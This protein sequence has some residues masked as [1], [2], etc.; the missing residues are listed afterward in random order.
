MDEDGPIEPVQPPAADDR[1]WR[2]PAEQGA[3][4]AAANLD[5]RRSYRRIWPSVCVAFVAGCCVVGLA[6]MLVDSKQRAPIEQVLVQEIAPS[7]IV[8]DGTLSFDDWVN[9]VAQLNRSSVVLLHLPDSAPTATAQAIL[10]RDD[11]HLMTS[12]HAIAGAEEITVEYAGGRLPA[13]IVGVDAVSGVAVL[14]INSPNLAPP[15][16]GDESRVLTR[17]QLVAL[18]YSIADGESAKA[19]DLHGKD[20]VATSLGGTPLAQLFALSNDLDAQ[21]AGS[22]LLSEDGG[23]IAMTVPVANGSSYAVPI[24]LARRVANQLIADGTVDHKPWIGVE[25]SPALSDSLKA[26]RGVRGGLLLTRVWDETPAARAGLV[27]GDIIVQA[28]SVNVF[29]RTD[30]NEALAV[31]EPGDTMEITYSTSAPSVQGNDPLNAPPAEPV[32]PTLFT[33]TIILGARP[34]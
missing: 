29:D 14:K 3:L 24:G 33:T 7:E 13:Q 6:W 15:T 21:W 8:F 26:Q 11:G 5:A 9:D 17:D 4:Q 1:L 31:L 18:A 27:A 32:E 12:A 25:L 22:A 34:A 19:V 23:I 28:G 30:F 2:H 16:F 10:L 20:Q